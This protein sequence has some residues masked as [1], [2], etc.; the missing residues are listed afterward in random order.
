MKTLATAILAI[1]TAGTM[2]TACSG[3]SDKQTANLTDSDTVVAK[4]PQAAP[5]PEI[6][7]TPDLTLLEVKGNVKEIKGLQAGDYVYGGNAKFD[8]EGTL[9][10]YGYSDPIVKLSNIKRDSDGNLT[11]FLADEWTTVTWKNGLPLSF[12]QQFNEITTIDTREFDEA[13]RVVKITHRYQDEIEGIDETQIGTVTY[14]SDAFD[15][16]GNW[17]R[18]TIKYPDHTETQ[19]RKIIYY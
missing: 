6:F 16:N 9:T 4:Q 17:T 7:S 1:L 3:N 13:G 5:E 11:Y 15:S 10:H 14:D 2:L 8:R 19:L 18:R 12:R